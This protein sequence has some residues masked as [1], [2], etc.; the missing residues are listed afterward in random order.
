MA[1]AGAAVFLSLVID[2]FARY[3]VPAPNEPHYLTKARHF[4]DPSWC[5]RD[6]FL[7]SSNAHAV[8]YATFGALTEGCSLSTSA[9]AGRLVGLLILAAGWTAMVSALVP[10]RASPLWAAWVYLGLAAAGNLSGEWIVGGIES[11]VVAYGFLFGALGVVCRWVTPSP[12]AARK[13]PTNASLAACAVLFGA[14]IAFHPVVGVWGLL[15]AGFATALLC[16]APGR[17]RSAD[18]PAATARDGKRA[19]AFALLGAAVAAPGVVAALR[20]TTGSSAAADYIQVY[21]RLAHH[22]D[23]MQFSTQAWAG[24]AAL[25]VGW[26]VARRWGLREA[27]ERWFLWFII[28]C[29]LIALAG[30]IVGWRA[31][32]PEHMMAYALRWKLLKFYPFRLFDAMLPIA[33]AIAVAGVGQR[34][35]RKRPRWARPLVWACLAAPFLVA[36]SS[37]ASDARPPM[38]PAALRDW[39]AACRWI[40]KNTPPDALVMTPPQ[41]SW[42]FKWFAQRAEFVSYKDCPQDG[43]G[44]LAWNKRMLEIREWAE[45]RFEGGYSQADAAELRDRYGITHIVAARLGPFA[46]EPVFRNGAFR[47]YDLRGLPAAPSTREP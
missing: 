8:F 26:L 14:A 41:E 25:V 15:A 40:E 20:G 4:W 30:L 39:I 6:L 5:G 44:I 38:S 46:F 27:G 45:R 43:P 42:A 19:A 33:V 34:L 37:E 24:Y 31:G 9:V 10:G 18:R 13:G 11:K 17:R 22:L 47:I 2:S 32:P 23:P 3:P 28:G 16:C 36:V 35:V 21:Y 12:A 7:S 29:A 1:V